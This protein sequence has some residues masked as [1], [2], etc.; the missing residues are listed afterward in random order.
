MQNEAKQSE[1]GLH[2][3]VDH[4]L[5]RKL[6]QR[7]EERPARPSNLSTL[8]IRSIIASTATRQQDS[9]TTQEEKCHH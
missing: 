1:A 4:P 8:P 9:D 2:E 5:A 3:E 6:H 7:Q